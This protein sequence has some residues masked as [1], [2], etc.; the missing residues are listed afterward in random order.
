M[1]L[2]A[3]HLLQPLNHAE[4]DAHRYKA[5]AEEYSPAILNWPQV[6]HHRTNPNHQVAESSS[7][8][9]KTL[10]EAHKM[11]RCHFGYKRQAKR[12]DK[13]LSYRQEE[14]GYN[15]NPR[16]CFFQTGCTHGFCTHRAEFGARR[17]TANDRLNHQE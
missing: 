10:A 12:A 13:Q 17:I 15:Q 4:H 3:C 16:P 9:P 2:V 6:I 14:V 5:N 11:T 8:Q 7:A 1:P